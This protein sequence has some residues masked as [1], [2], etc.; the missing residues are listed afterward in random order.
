[1]MFRIT[2][3]SA[4]ANSYTDEAITIYGKL[5]SLLVHDVYIKIVPPD[6]KPDGYLRLPTW[7]ASKT[8]IQT[9]YYYKD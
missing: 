5:V 6:S 4:L 2:R 7:G 8:S 3:A 9:L 1:M